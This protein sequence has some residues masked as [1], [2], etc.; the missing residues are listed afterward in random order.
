MLQSGSGMD[1]SSTAH[2][3]HTIFMLIPIV[4]TG[5]S[6]VAALFTLIKYSDEKY[7]VVASSEGGCSRDLHTL[8]LHIYSKLQTLILRLE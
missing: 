7:E 4:S 2:Q 8:T 5:V 1:T 3:E 6:R